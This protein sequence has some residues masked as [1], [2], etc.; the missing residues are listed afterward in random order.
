[1]RRRIALWIFQG[2]LVVNSALHAVVMAAPPDA[3]MAQM[4]FVPAEIRFVIAS[5]YMACALGMTL[6]EF[7]GRAKFV[8]VSALALAAVSFAEAIY[9]AVMSHPMPGMSRAI[10]AAFLVVF[11]LLRR[12][13]VHI[14]LV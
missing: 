8:I 11:A 6:P 2:I 13:L 4:G 3:M 7:F 10:I 12:R 14:P 5:V 9:M 1:M